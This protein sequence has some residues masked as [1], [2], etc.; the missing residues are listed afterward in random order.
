MKSSDIYD[1][2][3]LAAEMYDANPL[4]AD[5]FDAAFYVDE[6]TASG[7]DVLELGCGTGRTTIPIAEAGCRVTGLDLS[8]QMLAKCRDK[9]ADQSEEVRQRIS[10]VEGDMTEF[11]LGRTFALV[12][13]P[14][15]PFQHL[16]SVADQMACLSCVNRHLEIGGR[17]ILDMFHVNPRAMV[18]DEPTDEIEDFAEAVMPDGRCL[19]R[20]HRIVARHRSEH[21]NDAEFINYLT[22]AT[23]N[24]ERVVQAFAMRYFFRYEIE[25]LLARTGFDVTTIYGD[26]DRSLFGNDS[27]EMITVARKAHDA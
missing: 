16:V 2:H 4:Y 1:G 9:L 10:L 7:C 25:H 22:D 6:A 23:G 26:Y 24:S 21:Y 8:A 13:T 17:L 3:P 27:P 5:R 19:R 11:D 18:G 15:R 12:T 14:S 20:T